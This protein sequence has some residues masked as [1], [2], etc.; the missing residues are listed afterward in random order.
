MN[1]QT[2]LATSA[3]VAA[4]AA[5]GT[6]PLLWPIG[7]LAGPPLV[8]RDV[9]TLATTDPILNTYRLGVQ[10]MKALPA[11]DPRSWTYQ[12]AIHG[13][14]LSGSHTAWNTCQ[15]GTY[16]FWSWHRMYLWYF[17]RIIRSLTGDATWALPYWNYESASE[18]HLPAA[19]R[20][21]TS[22]LYTSNRGI[23]WNAGTAS[24][25]SSDVDTTTGMGF[26]DFTSASSSLEGNPHGAVHVRIGGWM[27]GVPTAA[28]DPIFYLHHA[29]I[30]RLWNLWKA[31][32]GGRV[33]PLTDTTWKNHLFTFFDE[34]QSPVN[35]SACSVLRAAQQLNYTYENEPTQ[36]NEYCEKIYRPWLY[37]DEL[38]CR[39]PP[40]P[41]P[42]G[43]R[44]IIELKLTEAQLAKLRA[45]NTSLLKSK[46]DAAL[47]KI[48]GVTANVQPGVV[49]QV[50]LGLRKGEVPTT[51]SPAF[52]G[53]LALFG[54]GVHS[55]MPQSKFM[56][57]NF[58]L[59]AD[60][61]LARFIKT[62]S[63]TL[64]IEFVATGP[65]IN[66][67]PSTPKIKSPVHVSSVNLQLHHRK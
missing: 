28:Q 2:F 30:D 47:L 60:R 37:I 12:A 50:Y 64:P 8:R 49:W 54:M 29:N 1:R 25:S 40:P 62:G 15:H 59:N 17:E 10:M 48:G 31:Q 56:P 35:L 57:A 42:L 52:V 43:P 5:V 36:V 27:G 46:V 66:G 11:S 22:T 19:F 45:V 21:S 9:G 33:D 23:G 16:Y 51:K 7:A 4:A 18:R 67:Q 53:N 20:D 6:E 34:S 24:L 3:K 38:I 32:G 41:D 55:D 61:A 44:T 63:H 39:W 65:L 14:T 13:T 58:A 26:F